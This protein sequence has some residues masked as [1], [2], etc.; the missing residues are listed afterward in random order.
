M[1]SCPVV[2]RAED[3][4]GEIM[5]GDEVGMADAG[6]DGRIHVTKLVTK[7]WG[8]VVFSIFDQRPSHFTSMFRLSPMARTGLRISRL[9]FDSPEPPCPKSAM[10]PCRV[11]LARRLGFFVSRI[12]RAPRIRHYAPLAQDAR[13]KMAPATDANPVGIIACNAQKKRR[14][15]GASAL[16]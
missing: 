11:A 5:P 13:K 15:P 8:R 1:L 4:A 7:H 16:R 3:G 9:L 10:P 6:R 2:V 12:R 14:S